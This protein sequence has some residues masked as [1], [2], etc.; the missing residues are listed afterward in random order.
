MPLISFPYGTDTLSFHLPH[1]RIK[2]I[3]HSNLHNFN[4][5][6]SQQQ[7][8]RE[9]LLNP[10]G[11][12]RLRDLARNKKKI[13]I[14]ASDHTRP[15]P[16]KIIAPLMLEEIRQENPE[17]QITFLIATGCHRGTSPAELAEKFGE[18]LLQTENFCIHDCDNKTNLVNLGS[19]PS[20]GELIINRTAAEADLLVSEGFIEPHFFAGFSGGRKSV[21][22][23]IASRQ[24]VLYN[25]NSKFI[26][27]PHSR[28]GILKGN[29]IHNDML[30]AAKAAHLAFICNVV[31]NS[32]K[33]VVFATSGDVDLAHKKGCDFLLEHC[34]AQ[35]H[36]ASIVIT[37][38]GGYPLD[39]NIYQAVKGMT[40]AEATVKKDGIIIMLAKSADGHGGD[41]FFKTFSNENSLEKMMK[42]F[43]DTPPEKTIVDQW[44]SQILARILIK[45]QVIY[46]SDAPDEMVRN[47]HM[48]PAHSIS[49]ALSLADKLLAQKGIINGDITVIPDGVSVIIRP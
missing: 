2:G 12:P 30:Y 15:V 24:T 36:P 11:T 41:S 33:E 40:A 20:G 7:I 49:E 13:V 22:P 14:L 35:A 4:S 29:L 5:E 23:G 16:S 26:A 28:T 45:A 25:H 31:I 3:L 48:I 8:V 47:F 37:T 42:N 32:K 34:Q 1:E 38:N 43:L 17:A 44:Q 10:I 39:Q 46:I 21:L 9:S 18:K 6:K 19:L 27:D